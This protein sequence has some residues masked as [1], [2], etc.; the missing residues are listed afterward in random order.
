MFYASSFV[1][2]WESCVSA[3]VC[4]VCL[5]LMC[6]LFLWLFLFYLFVLAFYGYFL[7]YLILLL[8]LFFL[9]PVCFLKRGR[10]SVETDVG[11]DG[12]DLRGVGRGNPNH[13]ILLETNLFSTRE[14]EK[15]QERKRKKEMKFKK[16][17]KRC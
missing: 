12:E 17:N 3:S 2:L 4:V 13:N 10:K 11:R 15:N 1:F 9:V 5:S 7:F 14:K 16:L 8:L 6:V